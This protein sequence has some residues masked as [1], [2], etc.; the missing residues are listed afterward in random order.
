MSRHRRRS[1][2][3]ALTGVVLAVLGLSR[4][5]AGAN[6]HAP[7][8]RRAIRVV[9]VRAV[10]AGARI[11]AADLGTVRLPAA[12]ASPHQLA[13]PTDAIGRRA[14]VAL[15]PGAP[16]M[17]AE[18]SASGGMADGREL[19]LRLDDAAGIPA[20]DLA[21]VRG[22]VYLTPPGRGSRTRL[23]LANVLVV[24]ARHDDSGSVATLVVSPA[25]VS[26]A[27]AAEVEGS[28]R[29]VVHGGAAR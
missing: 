2:A 11:A 6:G 25:A 16:V 15:V 17:D 8:G 23:V 7:A 26:D 22:D 14:A 10:A 19:A 9:A 28:L 5:G 29:L 3:F 12:W 21:D 27:I 1:L 24:S 13:D 18:V 4:L 20:G